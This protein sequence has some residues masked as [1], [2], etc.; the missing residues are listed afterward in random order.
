M[1][2]FEADAV[3]TVREAVDKTMNGQNESILDRLRKQ[4]QQISEST[5]TDLDI[6]G[7]DGE[8]FCR[9]KRLDA[10]TLNAIG[11][12]AQRMFKEPVDAASYATANM[13]I[14]ACDSLHFRVEGKEVPVS[15]VLGIDTPVK[16][17]MDLAR[18]LGFESEL[19]DP[20]T[21][22]A[23]LNALF[24]GNTLAIASH[25]QKLSAWMMHNEAE[26]DQEFLEG[27]L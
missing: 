22:R 10:R 13:L 2:E 3:A 16:Y 8:I 26:Q 4:R 25:S 11:R 1:S 20:P 18:A 15:E 9:Y 5:T 17:D 6:P 12:K 19:P 14:E 23:V 24:V 7:Y 21:A 27:E